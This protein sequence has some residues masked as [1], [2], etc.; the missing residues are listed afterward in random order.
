MAGYHRKVPYRPWGYYD[1]IDMVAGI[2]SSGSW[3]IR[4]RAFR[5]LMHHHHAEHWIVVSGTASV[6]RGE[7][8]FVWSEKRASPIFRSGKNTGSR[9][10][11][12][13]LPL[14]MIEV[15]SGS[16]PGRRRGSQVQFDDTYGRS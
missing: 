7:E 6:T 9:I 1:S 14:A 10:L 8:T 5:L 4:A 15:Q 13:R 11:A 3:S 16:Y 12:A 2:R